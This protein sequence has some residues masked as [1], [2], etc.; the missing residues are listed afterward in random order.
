MKNCD[1]IIL[2]R[3]STAAEYRFITY[4]SAAENGVSIMAYQIDKD[5]CSGCGACAENCPVGAI[6]ENDGVYEIDADTCLDCGACEGTCPVGA[7]KQA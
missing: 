3:Y 1:R 2:Y 4:F 6:S 7:P 5:T